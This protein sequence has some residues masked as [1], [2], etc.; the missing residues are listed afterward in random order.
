MRPKRATNLFYQRVGA[1]RRGQF[2]RHGHEVPI[3]K[4]GLLNLARRANHI[5]P[6]VEKSL[7]H[8]RAETAVGSGYEHNLPLHLRLRSS[9][10]DPVI[11]DSVTDV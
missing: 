5:G 9:H 1:L 7:R 8:M 6:R 2:R 4:F 3:S 11:S 10:F